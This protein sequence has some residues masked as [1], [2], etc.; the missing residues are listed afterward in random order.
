M[1][2]AVGT[3]PDSL[4]TGQTM[5]NSDLTKNTLLKLWQDVNQI[6]KVGIAL[7]GNRQYGE[8]IKT[9]V[10]SLWPYAS[11]HF[12]QSQ[13][14]AYGVTNAYCKP[15]KLGVDRWLSMIASYQQTK[16]HLCI[17]NCGTALTVDIVDKNGIHL[18]GLISPGLHM[19][20]SALSQGTEN[21]PFITETFAEG[22]AINTEAA[23]FNGTLSAACGFIELSVN[24][25]A[26]PTKLLMSGGDADLIAKH[27]SIESTIDKALVLKGLARYLS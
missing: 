12:I 7:V 3:H 25:Q 26:M 11:I 19:M 15:E 6:D 5:L 21:L 23:I 27:L 24:T 13:P 22:L 17:V 9:V 20:K 4:V 8:I 1:K 18:G 14:H 2:W 16:D 10:E